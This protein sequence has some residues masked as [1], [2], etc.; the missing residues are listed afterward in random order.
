M[1]APPGRP[2]KRAAFNPK[3]NPVKLKCHGNRVFGWVYPDGTL[4][5]ICSATMC[6]RAGH[7]V[8]HL[9][10]P[11][12]GEAFDIFVPKPRDAG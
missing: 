9:F 7:E 12:N 8:R 5:L 10:N 6:K 4:E 2:E 3:A 11:A 1:S